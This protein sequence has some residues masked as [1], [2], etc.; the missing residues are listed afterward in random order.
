MLPQITPALFRSTAAFVD[1]LAIDDNVSLMMH[2]D[3]GNEAGNWWSDYS[4]KNKGAVIPAGTAY[5]SGK[6]ALGTTGLFASTAYFGGGY[7]QWPAHADYNMGSGD[8]T[9]DFWFY[10]DTAFNGTA[11]RIVFQCDSAATATSVS[12]GVTLNTA[13]KIITSTNVGST[14]YNVTSTTAFTAPGWHHVA[15]VRTGNTL[16]LF[17]D[18]VQ[19]GGDVAISGSVNSSPNKLAIGCLG[20]STTQT[21]RGYLEELRISKGVARWTANFTPSAPYKYASVGGNDSFTK[22]LLHAGTY[23]GGK[24]A[25]DTSPSAKL[26]GSATGGAQISQAAAKFGSAS[27]YLAGGASDAW[28]VPAHID[29]DFG[30]GDFTIDF[31]ANVVSYPTHLG[32]FARRI[33]G[34]SNNCYRMVFLNNGTPQFYVMTGGTIQ[35]NVTGAAGQAPAGEGWVHW[36]V[37]RNGNNWRMYK[38]GVMVAEQNVAFTIPAFSGN[39]NIGTVEGGLYPF[40]GY[41]DE[42]RV[43]KGIARWTANFTPPKAPYE[44]DRATNGND[45]FAVLLLHGDGT[46]GSTVFPDS[47]FAAHGNATPAGVISVQPGNKFGGSSIQQNGAGYLTFPHHADWELGAGDFTIDWWE[48]R[49]G[50]GVAIA[51]DLASTYSPFLLSYDISGARHIYFTSNGSSWD[52]A[53]GA[54]GHTFGATTYNVWNHLAIVRRSGTF[55]AFKDGVLQNTWSPG[56]AAI[57]AN[58]SPLCIGAGQSGNNFNGYIDELRITKGIARWDSNFTPPNAAYS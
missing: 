57:L 37:V 5:L 23:H 48:Y 55:F 54:G 52:L 33:L 18:G 46:T 15:H 47:S 38:N 3:V 20:E 43:S 35:V 25:F 31:W 14:A 32:L 26:S 29:F 51:R 49:S 45:A 41:I 24:W 10:P 28:T 39:L 16:K 1:P 17:I 56:T 36:A 7:A 19:E 50:A 21:Y 42:F 11:R 2:F 27:M 53:N 44:P 4:L 22:L 12:F 8:F 6:G 58:G 9:V 30:A 13:N 34:D 40:N